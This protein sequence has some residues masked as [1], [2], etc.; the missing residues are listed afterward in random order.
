MPFDAAGLEG[1][2]ERLADLVQHAGEVGVALERGEEDDRLRAEAA[3]LG[4][5][6]GELDRRRRLALPGVGVQQ[7]D[8]VR[9]EG[10]VE[11]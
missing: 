4:V 5:P 11:Q 2:S 10:P 6:A 3:G 9:I 7:H 8:R 1:R